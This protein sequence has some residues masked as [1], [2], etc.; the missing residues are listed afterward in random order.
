MST[1]QPSVTYDFSVPPTKGILLSLSMLRTIPVVIA[2]LIIAIGFATAVAP[3][4]VPVGLLF[5]SLSFVRIRGVVL[6]EWVRPVLAYLVTEHTTLATCPSGVIT[7][8]PDKGMEMFAKTDM[9]KQQSDMDAKA[10]K[11]AKANLPPILRYLAIEEAQLRA[12]RAGIVIGQDKTFT[13]VAQF[14]STSPFGIL[15][16]D[17]KFAIL[18]QFG[19]VLRETCQDNSVIRRFS[20]VERIVPDISGEA[21]SWMRDHVSKASLHGG[22]Q[23]QIEDYAD[24]LVLLDSAAMSHEVYATITISPQARDKD[25]QLQELEYEALHF[26]GRLAATG[27]EMH[28]LSADDLY[29]TLAAHLEGMPRH[30]ESGASPGRAVPLGFDAQWSHLAIDGLYH[31][32]LAVSSWPRVPVGASWL[33]PLLSAQIQGVTRNLALHFQPTPPSLARTRVRMAITQ[34]EMQRQTRAR[35]GFIRSAQTEREASEA[36]RREQELVAGYGE[37]R[38]GAVVCISAPSLDLL[39][40]GT[41][42]V[43]QGASTSGIDLRPLYGQQPDGYAAALPIGQV[44]FRRGLG[45]W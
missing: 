1:T 22:T 17:E 10:L 32:S 6:I 44:G 28:V 23:E 40:D 19:S 9:L 39:F 42:R 14:S 12:L 37:H 30:L 33:S 8:D 21:E 13:V 25:K 41:R 3:L 45:G 5:I 26:F 24:L 27:L 4:A 43:I 18:S 7:I 34:S 35:W 29:A 38:I 31:R 36:V 2:G 15:S 16:A 20:F 11:K